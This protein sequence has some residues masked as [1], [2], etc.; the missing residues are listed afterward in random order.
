MSSRFLIAAM[1]A[2]APAFAIDVQKLAANSLQHD[3]KNVWIP[4]HF[5]DDTHVQYFNPVLNLI[6]DVPPAGATVTPPAKLEHPRN[7]PAIPE[8]YQVVNTVVENQE[9][10]APQ[11]I[12][13]SSEEQIPPSLTAAVRTDQAP[14]GLE[15]EQSGEGTTADVEVAAAHGEVAA[16]AGGDA[17]EKKVT[18][19]ID[20]PVSEPEPTPVEQ[21]VAEDPHA[22]KASPAKGAEEEVAAKY[23]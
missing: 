14:P 1:A 3:Q 11:K 5:H 12:E 22:E 8:G 9:P 18:P 21:V 23:F 6:Q 15:A 16:E 17:E 7:T 10:A 2:T 13:K 19:P 20:E 4:L